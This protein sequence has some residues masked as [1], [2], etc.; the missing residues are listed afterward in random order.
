MS[1]R[2]CYLIIIFIFFRSSLINFLSNTLQMPPVISL[3]FTELAL[4]AAT[5]KIFDLVKLT[6]YDCSEKYKCTVLL[7]CICT[8]LSTGPYTAALTANV[9]LHGRHI[10]LNCD[11]LI[12]D[13]LC[14]SQPMTGY[15]FMR[16]NL[17]W[18]WHL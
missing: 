14:V 7:Q 15:Y 1:I 8:V 4:S 9:Q 11:W 5:L 2:I 13:W 16:W 17:I 6:R 18:N 10:F 12:L 3:N